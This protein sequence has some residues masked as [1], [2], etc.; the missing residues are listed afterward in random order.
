MPEQRM[1]ANRQMARFTSTPAF[2]TTHLEI[3]DYVCRNPCRPGQILRTTAP[4][5]QRVDEVQRVLL[6]FRAFC[7]WV[8]DIVEGEDKVENHVLA[9]GAV[10]FWVEG[11]RG[12][13]VFN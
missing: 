9:E 1:S 13:A 12:F 11:V 2:T 4:N 3:V 7:L 5:K 10:N 6:V 8:G